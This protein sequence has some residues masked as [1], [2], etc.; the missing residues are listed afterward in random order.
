MSTNMTE[1]DR[2][3]W[4]CF[5]VNYTRRFDREVMTEPDNETLVRMVKGEDMFVY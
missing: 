1:A 2:E 4:L 5:L 3:E